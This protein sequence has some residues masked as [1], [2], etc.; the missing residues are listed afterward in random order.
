M[1]NELLFMLGGIAL[2]VIAAILWITP[3]GDDLAPVAPP[4]VAPLP[5]PSPSE[6]VQRIV[7]TN[8][9]GEVNMVI[10]SVPTPVIEIKDAKGRNRK[11]D[12]VKL[13]E[14]LP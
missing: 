7:F 8:G 10:T 9:A 13:I 5:P 14:R 3:S 12:L 1:K 6:S 2:G 4:H 11:L